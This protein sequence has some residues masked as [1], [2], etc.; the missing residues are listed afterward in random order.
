MSSTPSSDHTETTDHTETPPTPKA[1][2]EPTRAATAGDR[3]FSWLRSL[4]VRREPGWIGGVC[5]GIAVR[6][7]I[8]PI[9]VRGIAVVIAVLGGPAILLY[10]AAW[11]LLPDAKDKIHLEQ[12]FRGVVEPAIAGIAAFFV[13]AMLPVTQGFWFLG[14][15]FWGEPRWGD[16]VG[17]TLW[18]LV[19]LGLLV[20][21]IV[22]LARR[23]TG[24]PHVPVPPPAAS[25]VASE[26]TVTTPTAPPKDATEPELA[27]WRE[28]QAKVRAEQEAFRNQQ[29]SDRAA[30]ARAA[31]EEARAARA[32]QRDKERAE[33]ARTRSNPLFSLVVI[34][35]ALVA[36]GITTV[37]LS[38][39][40]PSS[41]VI[42]FVVGAAAALAV[43]ALGIVING[44]RG[45]RSGG[46]S[47]LAS[48]L[49]VPLLI[50][51]GLSFGTDT[52]S[53]G[54]GSALVVAGSGTTL[55]PTSSQDY[56]IGAGRVQL[57]LT[58]LPSPG[59]AR[60][61]P[62][63]IRLVAGAGEITVIVPDD[64]RVQ[65][66]GNV[67]AG[68]IDT[69]SVT[70]DGVEGRGLFQ[71]TFFD[72]SVRDEAPIYVSVQLGAGEIRVIDEGDLR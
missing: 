51:W 11:L 6:L 19:L 32:V 55:T 4:D 60:E 45:K 66:S 36:G 28:Q 5:A 52:L 48:V 8:D 29:A 23:S 33:W 1:A 53:L 43:L 21:L 58:E 30:A 59:P 17:R 61:I 18:T 70:D 62:D 3:F 14:A 57:D 27:D 64:A 72:D 10:A 9:I 13:L 68:S 69:A 35:L 20:W 15:G 63:S 47:G 49:L 34:G 38:T 41:R 22:W 26:S 37:W 42:P 50:V 25:F 44:V 7:G 71:S 65:F 24:A 56:V 54:R 40:W 16:A 39:A 31:A 46:A 12:L 67:L 2:P